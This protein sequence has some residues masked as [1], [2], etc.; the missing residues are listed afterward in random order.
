MHLTDLF[1]LL[2]TLPR[3]CRED[4]SQRVVVN[5]GSPRL[6][7]PLQQS[8]DAASKVFGPV[9]RGPVRPAAAPDAYPT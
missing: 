8:L 6:A 2:R 7:R 9:N 3:S 1:F 4:V 5:L